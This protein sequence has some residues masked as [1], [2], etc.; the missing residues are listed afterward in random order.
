M[1]K[2]FA[3]FFAKNGIE[4]VIS[5]RNKDK[6]REVS[7]QLGVEA[8]LNNAEAVKSA[9]V[10]LLSVPIES[11]EEIV[12]Q[13]APFTRPEQ[14][15]IDITSV[16][17][18]PVGAMHQNIKAGTVLGAHPLF[19]PGARDVANQNF[20]LT[21]TSEAEEALA[22]KVKGYLEAKKA[23]VSLMS[24]EEHDDMMAII[25]GLAHFVAIV[26]ADTLLSSGKMKKVEAFGGIT[27]KVLLTLVESVLT[28]DPEL[29]ASIQTSLPGVTEIERL[30]QRRTE[31]WADLIARKDRDTFV[32]KMNG[33][34]AQLEQVAPD[35][36]K[37]YEN[38]YKIAGSL[39]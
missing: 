25:L 10:I 38:M 37:A 14:K 4:V 28:E 32:Q 6:L 9:D 26:S 34:K 7:E 31:D 21:P 3:G 11:F 5:G 35:F 8:A 23:R 39:E 36:G 17:V 29:Y 30:F 1:G 18:L 24:P 2:W 33:L 13:I 12:K 22:H 16:K 20:I 19:G 15:I 27:Y